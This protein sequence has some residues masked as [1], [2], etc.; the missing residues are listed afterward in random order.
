MWTFVRGLSLWCRDPTTPH[1]LEHTGNAGLEATIDSE[2]APAVMMVT[3][4]G[5]DSGEAEK[6]SGSGRIPGA[7]VAVFGHGVLETEESGLS[8]GLSA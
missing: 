6:W 4:W 2:P 8:R 1:P 7:G 5:S 3:D